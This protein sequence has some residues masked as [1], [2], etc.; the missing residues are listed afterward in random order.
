MFR[1][2]LHWMRNEDI[3]KIES[4]SKIYVLCW[5]A[6]YFKATVVKF[7]SRSR[8]TDEKFFSYQNLLEWMCYAGRW[9]FYVIKFSFS[10]KDDLHVYQA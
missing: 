4:G 1:Q 5:N 7:L 2:P 8:Q 10:M 3:R 6:N 9:I